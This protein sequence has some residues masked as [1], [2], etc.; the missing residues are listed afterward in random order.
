MANGYRGEVPIEIAG[1]RHLVAYGWE[2]VA[3][4]STEVGR[5]W[6]ARLVQAM[7]GCDLPVV[8][9]FLAIGLRQS[10]PGVTP[11][12]VIRAQ[13]PINVAY[14]AI[15]RGLNVTFHGVTEVAEVPAE[16]GPNPPS[17]LS[18][19]ISAIRFWRR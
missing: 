14:E 15:K 11:D 12:D 2:G 1:R 9:Q 13:P 6:D 10:W 3:I 8:A 5:D 7:A 4:L 16:P 19:T 18:R 17:L